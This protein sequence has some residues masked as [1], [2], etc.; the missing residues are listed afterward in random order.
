[1]LNNWR[2]NPTPATR[3]VLTGILVLVITFMLFSTWYSLRASVQT[4]QAESPTSG[5]NLD[6]AGFAY[7]SPNS[8]A[9]TWTHELR[10][11]WEAGT[12]AWLDTVT[13]SG[14]L[15]LMTQYFSDQASVTP[16]LCI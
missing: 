8:G 12:Y 15:Q 6:R 11:D 7:A 14:T 9:Y 16:V 13:L 1:M 4:A 2:N 3:S 10:S 5:L